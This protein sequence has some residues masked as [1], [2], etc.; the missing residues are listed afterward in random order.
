MAAQEEKKRKARVTLR[1]WSEPVP[2]STRHSYMAGSR[3]FGGL[4]D[5]F[6]TVIP[7]DPDRTTLKQLRPAIEVKNDRGMNR[8]TPLFQHFLATMQD[9]ATNHNP[10]NYPRCEATTYRFGLFREGELT[11]I[12]QENEGDLVSKW[13]PKPLEEDLILVPQSQIPPKKNV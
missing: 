5:R 4:S 13:I 1:T 2:V 11:I 3:N 12:P 7:F 8:R 6:E 9:L 10:H